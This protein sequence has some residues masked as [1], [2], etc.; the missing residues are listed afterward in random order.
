MSWTSSSFISALIGKIA[1]TG[2]K[3]GFG[4]DEKEK[5]GERETHGWLNIFLSEMY[6]VLDRFMCYC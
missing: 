2:G 3:S 4:C 5:Y 6:H 1:G